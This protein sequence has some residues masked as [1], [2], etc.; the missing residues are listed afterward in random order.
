[1][2][3][4][5]ATALVLVTAGSANAQ[6]N[7]NRGNSYGGGFGSNRGMSGTGSNPNSYYVHPS[8]RMDGGITSGHYRTTPNNTQFD[9]YGTRGNYNPHTGTYGTRGARY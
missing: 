2:K 6:Y 1:M 7:Y 8:P 9:N 5:I 4:V 3:I